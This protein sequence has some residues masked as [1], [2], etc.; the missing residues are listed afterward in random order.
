[1]VEAGAT[2]PRADTKLVDLIERRADS[3]ERGQRILRF[4]RARTD[5]TSGNVD[6]LARIDG[7]MPKA[8]E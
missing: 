5:T 6:L 3:G 2:A 8:A 1:L 7:L 4:V